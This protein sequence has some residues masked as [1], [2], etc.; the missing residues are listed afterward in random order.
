MKKR[1]T[2]EQITGFLGVA[3]AGLPIK[4]RLSRSSLQAHG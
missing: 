3:D 4:G 2:E 1:Y